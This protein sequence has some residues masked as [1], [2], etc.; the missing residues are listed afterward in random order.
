MSASNKDL[1]YVAL[2]NDLSD[3]YTSDKTDLV[4]ELEKNRVQISKLL[5]EN[6][7]LQL[8]VDTLQN[9]INSIICSKSWRYTQTFRTATETFRK[10]WPLIRFKKHQ[11]PITKTIN[12]GE[13]LS[14]FCKPKYQLKSNWYKIFFRS[15]PAFF[16]LTSFL[17]YFRTDEHFTPNNRI[18]ITLQSGSDQLI[19]LPANIKEFR[20]D[21]FA[22]SKN[23]KITEL[24]LEELGT[25]QVALNFFYN[26]ILKRVTQIGLINSFKK[27]VNI[28][29]AKDTNLTS[30][31]KRLFNDYKDFNNDY[32]E[33]YRKFDSITINDE[34]SIKR[35]I[36]SFKFQPLISVVMPVFNTPDR[37]LKEA[38]ESVRNQLYE[39]WELCIT[40]D[41]S[42]TVST[43]KILTDYAQ[44]DSRI[45]VAFRTV[46]G[47]ISEAT[48]DCINQS[49]GKYISFLDHDDVLAK[50][51]LYHIVE[52]L[53][54]YPNAKF[55]Y[56]DEDKITEDGIRLNPY[57]KSSW[58][59][60][61]L[62]SQNYICHLLTVDRNLL[63]KTTCS[64]LK[65]LRS[66]YNGAQDWDLILRLTE[67]LDETE[68]IHIPYVLYHWRITETSTA[69]STSNKP[70]VLEAQK[71]AVEDHLSRRNLPAKVDI[72]HDISQLKV[73]F[74][75]P[76]KLPTVTI[77]I[78]TYNQVDILKKCI[79]SLI[80]YTDYN[81][82]E[83][84]VIDNRS[85]D[86]K[87]LEYLNQIKIN[88]NNIRIIPD[89][90][91]FNFAKL[92]NTAVK[93][94]NSDI[95]LFMNNDIQITTKDWL[96]L[97]VS[98]FVKPDTGA[99]GARLLYPNGLLQH[100]GILL[101]IGGVAGHSHKGR[102]Y[103]DVGYF[104]RI[105]LPH[106]VSAVTAACMAVKREIFD[107]V[108]GF[109]Q[110]KLAVAF[111]DVDL[112]LKIRSKGY[113]IVYCPYAE[114]VHH[115]SISRGY[116]TTPEKFK[117]FESE[118]AVMKERWNHILTK[119]PYYNP[120][121]TLLSEDFSFSFPPREKKTWM[122]I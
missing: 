76:E 7:R 15:T 81:D 58:N 16:E 91:P 27:L 104:N 63:V 116:E 60:D 23:Q 2:A 73:N 22:A 114:L 100:G 43:K 28:F 26:K 90:S 41:C 61:L 29:V 17:L 9:Q 92:N 1:N 8:N 89:E 99:V 86:P 68:I 67:K 96:K 98:Y 97:M 101:G 111:N 119:D 40:D 57:F 4:K 12:E 54:R 36:K 115:E 71:K 69:S 75:L 51:A 65:Y 52:T 120:N 122:N 83:V 102:P 109:D 19:K 108:G 55:L 11:L 121:L 84:L 62:L 93:H 112:C 30:I 33:W 13:Q 45:K 20:I 59:P 39:N 74:L 37:L 80:T 105:V 64:N 44:L 85:D 79:D 107:E 118:I 35:H 42:T 82:F 94:C 5:S 88:N 70:Y 117:R 32:F 53:Q 14:Y 6:Q 95:I 10:L 48:N 113:R 31:C 18:W 25:L 110:E 72:L 103:N 87:T 78:P 49:T 66:T 106:N 3:N 77:I 34:I 38:I 56:S 21:P 47:H 46:N 24:C 50:T